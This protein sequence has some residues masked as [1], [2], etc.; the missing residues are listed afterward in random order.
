MREAAA[1]T[2]MKQVAALV[3]QER[4]ALAARAQRSAIVNALKDL[5][6]EVREGMQTAAAHRMATWSC[7]GP[8]TRRWA[9]R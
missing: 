2:L 5:G 1:Q 3:E 8:R 6:Y 7:A 4:K 9:F